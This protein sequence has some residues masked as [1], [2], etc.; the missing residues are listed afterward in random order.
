MSTSKPTSYRE[1]VVLP[2]G[3]EDAT[4]KL[5]SEAEVRA[6]TGGDELDIGKSPEYNKHPNDLVY[7]SLLLAR[8][9]TRIGDKTAISI[10]DIRRLHARDVRALEQAVYRLT[11]GED[12]LPDQ[13]DAPSG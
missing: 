1:I 2:V 5:H 4:G 7:K 6:V 8:T 10:T 9:V 12:S 13:G 3:F 11:Y